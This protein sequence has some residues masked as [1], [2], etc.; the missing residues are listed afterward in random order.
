M[1]NSM[2]P[3][4]SIKINLKSVIIH[5]NI[6]CILYSPAFKQVHHY[7]QTILVLLFTI[8]YCHKTLF[9]GSNVKRAGNSSVFTPSPESGELNAFPKHRN[10]SM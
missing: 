3:F 6:Q 10:H 1:N 7:L 9:S 8:A 5:F 4:N 2:L